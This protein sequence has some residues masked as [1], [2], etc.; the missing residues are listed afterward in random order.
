MRNHNINS[1]NNDNTSTIALDFA[2]SFPPVPPLRRSEKPPLGPCP[3]QRGRCPWAPRAALPRPSV[4][5]NRP[6]SSRH[7]RRPPR[8][9][10]PAVRRGKIPRQ[11]MNT[12]VGTR[13]Q[14]LV[15]VGSSEPTENKFTTT[16][17]A[18]S[19]HACMHGTHDAA[20]A[21]L[22]DTRRMTCCT[23]IGSSALNRSIIKPI[24]PHRSISQ[25]VSPAT[26]KV[27][28]YT[29]NDAT[30]LCSWWRDD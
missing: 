13:V 9:S 20:P 11:E 21:V 3:L 10:S 12:I 28:A 6:G 18:E 25:S 5:R 17:Q 27:K 24:S 2:H 14:D 29:L 23:S 7:A 16:A 22:R 1:N 8:K 30:Q 15:G 26:S 4:V 19:K